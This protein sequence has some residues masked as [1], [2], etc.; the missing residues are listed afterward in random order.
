MSIA[1]NSIRDHPIADDLLEMIL[2]PNPM[3][4][5]CSA[6]SENA[7]RICLP[8]ETQQEQHQEQ[9]EEQQEEQQQEQQGST[10][11]KQQQ[12]QQKEEHE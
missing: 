2:V 8:P 3:F 6:S 12:E 7:P 10:K 5:N 11:K 1:W 4:R 9:Q